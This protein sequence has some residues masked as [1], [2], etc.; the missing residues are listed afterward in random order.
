MQVQMFQS[1][2][3]FS[4]N[5][6]VVSSDKGNVLID[7]GHHDDEIR[8]CLRRIG[9]LD[10]ILLTHGHWDHTYG[11]DAVKVDYPDA[12]VYMPRDG[13]DFLKNPVLN[14]SIINGFAE[15]VKSDVT[16]V[17]EGRLRVAG[18]DVDVINTPG[19]CRGCVL[20]YFEDE[21]VLFTGDT[22]MRDVASPIRPTG[23]AKDQR[24]S[25]RKFM[26]LG[27]SSGT[28]VYPGHGEA[29]TYGWLLEN[30]TEVRGARQ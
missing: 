8:D 24:E 4:C 19:H 26:R 14:G 11:L 6:Y 2:R 13:H 25:I 18:Y 17:D 22:I 3:Q 21:G 5:V 1:L 9:G 20:Y 30:N 10:A 7:P 23:S 27:Y 16:P 15:V 12:P 28:P 29:T